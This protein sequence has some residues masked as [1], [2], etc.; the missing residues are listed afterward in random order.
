MADLTELWAGALHPFH[1]CWGSG[2]TRKP[3]PCHHHTPG[4]SH[5]YPNRQL[6]SQDPGLQ[7]FLYARRVP[8]CW[9]CADG[10]TPRPQNEHWCSSCCMSDREHGSALAFL[11][12]T[13]QTPFQTPK[14]ELNNFWSAPSSTAGHALPL[15]CPG[16]QEPSGGAPISW[17]PP[18]SRGPP[19]GLLWI[20]RV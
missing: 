7:H 14:S 17:Q 11:V 4:L 19:V 5:P 6:R 9:R 20:G 18:Q 8:R 10:G 2:Y 16:H 12:I 3:I 15:P 13:A 1:H